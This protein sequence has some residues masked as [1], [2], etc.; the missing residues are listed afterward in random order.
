MDEIINTMSLLMI[1]IITGIVSY[2]HGYNS[3]R[4]DEYE[5]KMDELD[6]ADGRLSS[7]SP[8]NIVKNVN[9]G[10]S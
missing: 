6:K 1:V 4:E 7:E 8:A 2:Y 10:H 9:K 5:K 3:G